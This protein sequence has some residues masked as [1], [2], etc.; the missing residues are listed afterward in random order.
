MDSDNYK[1]SI[2][3]LPKPNRK[4]EWCNAKIKHEHAK[5][6]DLLHRGT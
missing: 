6:M 5:E 4:G 3:T 1:E 2:G